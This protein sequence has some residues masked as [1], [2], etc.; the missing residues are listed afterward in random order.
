MVEAVLAEAE[1]GFG[2]L[3]AIAVTV[4]PGA[5][6]GLRIGLA[7]AR[8][9][10]LAAGLPLV[11]VTT[12]E[13]VAHGVPRAQTGSN[14]LVA[15][16]SKRDDL[17]VQPFDTAL[18]P[19]APPAALLPAAIGAALA[20]AVP[21][22]RLGVVGDAAD[23]ALAA[24]SGQPDFQTDQVNRL[25]Q[26]K[27]DCDRHPFTENHGTLGNF[28]LELAQPSVDD[29]LFGHKKQDDRQKHKAQR[30]HHRSQDTP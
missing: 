15:L 16:D 26:T 17:Y 20:R 4:G 29:F 25:F 9:M 8:G 28:Y 18:A 21:P 1:C 27:P 19:L 11:G 22:G 23:R 10:A 7:A 13:A 24:I 3:D 30:N 6:T 2:D 12:L 5:F 14:L